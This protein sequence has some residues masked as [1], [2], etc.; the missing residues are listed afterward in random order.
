MILACRLA[1][2]ADTPNR[3]SVRG[4][5]SSFVNPMPIEFTKLEGD[6][7]KYGAVCGGNVERDW[8]KLAAASA[9]IATGM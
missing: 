3:S 1:R 7:N 2:F 4:L 5:L 8:A 9:E 6:G